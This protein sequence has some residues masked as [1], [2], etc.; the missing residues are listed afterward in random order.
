M[1]V[2]SKRLELLLHLYFDEG[3][4][5]ET[6]RELEQLLLS[7]PQARELFWARAG[8][9]S[10]LRQWGQESWGYDELLTDEEASDF[11]ESPSLLQ[12]RNG[13][14]QFHWAW[15]TVACAILVAGAAVGIAVM[16]RNTMTVAEKSSVTAIDGAVTELV[17]PDTR[18]ASASELWVAVLRKAVSVQW[19]ENEN[20]INAGEVMSPRRIQLE[21]GLVQIQTNRG[22]FIT[23]EGPA[24]LEVVSGMEVFCRSGKLRV[25]VPPSAIG[26][27]VNTP[28]IDVVDRG[29]SFTVSVDNQ[30]KTEVHVLDGL[31]ELVSNSQ[32][33][34]VRE[35]REG[36]SIGVSDGVFRDAS[37]D[38][39]SFPS[40]AQVLSRSKSEADRN[41]QAWIR[42]RD[43]ISA[44]PTCVLYF[45]FQDSLD[46]TTT[47]VNKAVNAEANG[48]I[49]GGEWAEGRWPE[50]KALD[51]KN[52]F[53]RILFSVPGEYVTLTCLASVRLD[54]MDAASTTLPMPSDSLEGSFRWQITP[55][56][57][58]RNRGQLNFCWRGNTEWN[59]ASVLAGETSLRSEQLGAWMQ[60]AVV[61]DSKNRICSQYIDGVLISQ[62]PI[63]ASSS[64]EPFV[65][66]GGQMEFGNWSFVDHEPL[67]GWQHFS[68]RIDELIM[69]SRPLSAT[70]ITTHHDL[71]K[72]TWTGASR[73]GNW[74]N[75]NNW[76]EGI[77]PAIQDAVY[78]DGA[79]EAAAVYS[80]GKS[81]LFNEIRV[82]SKAG[83]TGELLVTGG[84]LLAAKHNSRIGVLGG[85]GRI[86]QQGG[87]V[88]LNSLQVALDPASLGTY[89]LDD[90]NLVVKRSVHKTVG[91]IDIGAKGGDGL[92][93]VTGGSLET[94]IGVTLGREGGIGKF[95][96]H[97]SRASRIAI[98]AHLD[99]SGFWAQNSGS[100]LEALVDE[101][102]IT[103]IVISSDDQDGTGSS[104]TFEDGALLDVGFVDAPKAG[105]W[106]VMKWDGDLID[107]GLRFAGDV[108]TRNW[109]FEFVDSDNSG[110]PDTLRVTSRQARQ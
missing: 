5:S 106:D 91:S 16:T 15:V 26:F 44:D 86:H 2:D 61:W 94:R 71:K 110:H 63:E 42:R 23:L 56:E 4:D 58:D 24:D 98:G 70:E 40:A 43:A 88:T 102:G 53:D 38:R 62:E 28:S 85:E 101:N 29:T 96:I 87:D 66:R 1:P 21:S 68:G 11:T 41:R 104:V 69:F 97:G 76:S 17:A 77:V 79:D 81:K 7:S 9:N 108:D 75:V 83:V 12:P 27:L 103:P 107:H 65:L 64:T 67:G 59:S 13:R 74:N 18:D 92:L 33:L 39:A 50:K 36:E 20:P 6:K 8:L 30:E 82:G 46:N 52:A 31:V 19:S 72:V 95:S 25:D 37:V 48:T 49:V 34:P 100:V 14:I 73:D 109:S 55:T 54:D 99:G 45:D 3:L 89:R 105:S 51:L 47:L 57:Q 60:L 78:I 90:G 93:E 80:A 84:M 10:M 22:V 32:N 35:L